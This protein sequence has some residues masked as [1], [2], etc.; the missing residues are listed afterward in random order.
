MWI[1]AEIGF[2]L[3]KQSSLEYCI[4]MVLEA[5]RCRSTT[6][7]GSQSFN[8]GPGE[9][10]DCRWTYCKLRLPDEKCSTGFD[11]GQKTLQ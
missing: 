8:C 3:K 2:K 1:S 4:I 9:M 6:K 7:N 10:M 11:G 5:G